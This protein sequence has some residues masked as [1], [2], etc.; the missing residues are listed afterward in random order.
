MG[1]FSAEI[2]LAFQDKIKALD[3]L[4]ECN[5]EKKW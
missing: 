1:D 4:A 5:S 2:K 3:F